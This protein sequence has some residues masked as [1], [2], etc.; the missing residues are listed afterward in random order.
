MF[1]DKETFSNVI[2]STPLVS[3][4]LVVKNSIG[5]ALLGKR[6]NRPAKDSWFVPGGRI[7]K[8]E[9]MAEAFKRLTHDELGQE[10]VITQAELLGVYDHFY[11]DNVFGDKFTTHYVVIAYVLILDE[12][13]DN[14]P[15][16]I[17]H[18]GYK[19]FNIQDLLVDE[20]V[21]EHTKWYFE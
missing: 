12:E 20:N 21:H 10:L 4:D 17:Q 7:L 16:D 6:L 9:S 11:E 18:G 13:L 8:N 15:L 2:E 14:L 1:L 5:Q 19:C 3:I